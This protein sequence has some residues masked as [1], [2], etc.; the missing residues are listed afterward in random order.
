ML[1]FASS[2]AAD[3]SVSGN[4]AN[5]QSA[6][7][8]AESDQDSDDHE[9]K[10]EH[11][12]LRLSDEAIGLQYDKIPERP[13]PLLELGESFLAT[14]RVSEPFESPTGAVWQPQFLAFGEYRTGFNFWDVNG[15]N[16]S[17]GREI[18]WTNH[19]ELYGQLR[20]TPTERF[21]IG[22]S[23]LS[24]DGRFTGHRYISEARGLPHNKGFQEL[25][26]EPIAAFFE[27]DLGELFP[28]LDIQDNDALDIGFTIGR[29]EVGPEFQDGLL[30][31][32]RLD[33]LG[34]TRNTIKLPG[35]A[36]FRATGIWA[37]GDVH[38]GNGT[39]DSTADL[40]ALMLAA[41]VNWDGN[42]QSSFELD[43]AWVSSK[44]ETSSALFVAASAVQRIDAVA[45]TLRYAYS[46]PFDQE[47]AE[48]RRG[49]LFLADVSFR[50][51]SNNDIVYLS[52]YAG[53]GEYTQAARDPSFGSPLTNTGILFEAVGLGD[54]PPALGTRPQRQVGG[55]LGCQLFFFDDRHQLTLEV[56]GVADPEHWGT[57]D[58]GVGFRYQFASYN[59]FVFRFDGWAIWPAVGTPV[60]GLRAEMLV[61]F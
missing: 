14:G 3:E 24:R 56:A 61:R 47:S 37:W 10:H 19:L 49:H 25:N 31:N 46:H 20:L 43:T 39:E 57:H 48:V 42:S 41:D 28:G 33:M 18:E 59:R 40:F 30:I 27:G 9:H 26:A 32:D 5:D 29:N 55:A 52:G 6:Q 51:D 11:D 54:M 35:V 16:R 13:A 36:N 53:V 44:H 58:G 34:I 2:L 23:P 38:R 15:A 50:P 8:Q 7:D 4:A 21:L 60:T 17:R 12:E 1:L 22:F 45:T